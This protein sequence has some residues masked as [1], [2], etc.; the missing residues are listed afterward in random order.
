MDHMVTSY[1]SDDDVTKMIDAYDWY[2]VPVM[3]PDGYVYSWET[4]RNWRKSRNINEG[5]TCMGTDLNRNYDVNWGLVGISTNPCSDTYLGSAPASEPE[6]EIIQGEIDRLADDL[7]SF[8]TFHTAATMWLIPWGHSIDGVCV[9]ADDHEEMMEI[10]NPTVDAIQDTHGDLSWARGNSCE[11]IYAT[12]GTTADYAKKMAPG[13]PMSA[14]PE[15][16][17]SFVMPPESITP[18]FEE[19]WNGIKTMVDVI[20][21]RRNAK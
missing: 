19:N 20:L 6:T 5:S 1:G 17:G 12:S 9:R 8:V 13:L 18:S 4:N 2:F 3:N 15:L 7:D 21:E 16:R 11:T 14:T 10:L